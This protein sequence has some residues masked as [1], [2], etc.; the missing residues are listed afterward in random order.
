MGKQKDF[1]DFDDFDGDLDEDLLA[2]LDDDDDASLFDL[3][4]DDDDEEFGVY[5]DST[6][7][8]A[9]VEKIVKK[10]LAKEKARQGRMADV[11]KEKFGVSP[12]EA[13]ALIDE[14]NAAALSP[15]THPATSPA[16]LPVGASPDPVVNNL[17]NQWTEFENERRAE[18]EAADFVNN[19]PN[20]K[21]SE[22]PAQVIARRKAGGVTLTE[23][24]KM[25]LADNLD[26]AAAAARKQ[27]AQG[28]LRNAQVGRAYRT[29]GSDFSASA[30]VSHDV[31]VL[32]AD[33]RE[34]AQRV[35]GMSPKAYLHYKRKYATADKSE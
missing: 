4:L 9:R 28:A 5:S 18:K 16:A 26:A 20:V 8:K 22:I 10:R 24:Y 15:A 14:Q 21:H 7:P 31:D 27:G 30:G 33:E 34:F 25:Y 23:A 2:G 12:E 13:I 6:I 29:E 1:D 3:D 35:L 17:V 11:F 19:F 32:D